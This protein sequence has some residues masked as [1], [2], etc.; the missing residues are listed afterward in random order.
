MSTVSCSSMND[1]VSFAIEKEEK[2]MDFYR[3]CS[4]RA[5]N[6]G[7]KQFF[8][9]MVQEEQ[10]HRDMLRDLDTLGLDN[11][12]L[13]AV[14]DL[15]ISDYMVDIPFKDDLSYQEALTIAMKKEEKAHAFYAAWKGKCASEK[16]A[17]LFEVLENEEAKHKRKLENLYDDEILTWD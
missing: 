1:V 7:I 12:K 13:P 15:R 16:T 11:V 9:E 14:E 6:P 10:R 8:E 17:K 3:Q 5:K 4:V 2:A